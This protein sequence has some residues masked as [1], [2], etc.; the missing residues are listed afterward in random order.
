MDKLTFEFYIDGHK[1]IID[2]EDYSKIS[3][4][5]W[6]I[7]KI[8][9]DHWICLTNTSDPITKKRKVF[10]LHQIIMPNKS[11]KLRAYFKDGN[12]LNCSKENIEYISRNLF[13]HLHLKT[14][15]NPIKKKSSEY[16]GVIKIYKARI[17][18]NKKL[19]CLGSFENPEDAAKAYNEK[20]IE[21]YGINAN[22]NLKSF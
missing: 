2:K 12:K 4:F 17:R 9:G 15:Q 21:L 6:K 1:V 5:N 16:K 22:V 13:G 18:Y 10:W 11:A 8:K 7:N 3:E 14:Q 19:Y 20:A